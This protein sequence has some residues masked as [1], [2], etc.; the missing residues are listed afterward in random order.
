MIS[1]GIDVSKGK[2]VV[3]AMKPGGEVLFAPLEILHTTEDLVSLATTLQNYSEEVRVVLEATGHYHWPVVSLLVENNIFVSCINSLRMSRYCAQDIR[4]GKS[5][6]IDS[7]KIASYGI[8]YWSDLEPISPTGEAYEELR[9]LSRQYYQH[10]SFLIKAKINLG[11]LLD[12]TMPGIKV[13]LHSENRTNKYLYVVERYWHFGNILHM[14]ETA[15]TNDFCEWGKEKRFL[16]NKI[17]ANRIFM[18]AH[19][20]ITTL[21]LSRSTKLVMQEAIKMVQE[22]EKS[23]DVILQRM[24]ELACGLPE[25]ATVLAMEGVGPILAPRLIAEIGDVRRF[26]SGSALIAYTGIDAPEKQS[27]SFRAEHR[28]ISKRGN[29]YLRKTGYEIM[30]TI[31]SNK[32]DN[33]AVYNFIMKKKAEGKRGKLALIAGLNKFLRIYYAR[34]KEVY[35]E[36]EARFDLRIAN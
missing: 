32:P 13:L 12:Q 17:I 28:R 25:Y 22:A 4:K 19:N 11:N 10:T 26:H 16:K 36:T 2:S 8:A 18:L 35:Q 29:K 31:T 14:G 33:D 1:V 21:P 15:F 6:K 27:G 23:K 9:F 30:T 5:D 3:C 7:I 34:V 20:G 24:Q